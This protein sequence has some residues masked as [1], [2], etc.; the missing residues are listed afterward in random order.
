MLLDERICEYF[1][2]L[3]NWLNQEDAN[4]KDYKEF[5]IPKNTPGAFSLPIRPYFHLSLHSL[6]SLI[7]KLAH[8]DERFQALFLTIPGYADINHFQSRKIPLKKR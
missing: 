6:L 1:Q 4:W 2:F 7:E 3:I 8:D 5:V